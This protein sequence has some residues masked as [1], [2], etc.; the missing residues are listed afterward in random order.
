MAYR[1]GRSSSSSKRG[2]V[3]RNRGR[4]VSGRRV[5]SRGRSN[6][7]PARHQTL[8]IVLE[9]PPSNPQLTVPVGRMVDTSVPQKAKF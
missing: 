7:S 8:R 6:A 3:S 2:R 4:S 5:S 9:H 1:R